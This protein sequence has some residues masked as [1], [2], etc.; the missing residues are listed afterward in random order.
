MHREEYYARI[1][2]EAHRKAL[3][4]DG[5]ADPGAWEQAPAHRADALYHA[6]L[7]TEGL[8]LD[9]V[10]GHEGHVDPK[11]HQFVQG[12]AIMRDKHV[13]ALWRLRSKAMAAAT[14]FER[15]A[16][17]LARVAE[18]E[19]AQRAWEAERDAERDAAEQRQVEAA[20]ERERAA[21]QLARDLAEGE[22]LRRERAELDAQRAA[23]AERVR[24]ERKE[25]QR[26]CDSLVA[27]AGDAS[28]Y[29]ADYVEGPGADVDAPAADEK[30]FR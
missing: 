5:E 16:E 30:P 21:A 24:L 15:T 10:A 7:F 11:T 4:K 6:H 28:S 17:H 23:E 20:A 25:K 12:K 13:M 29:A 18:G 9:P 8:E 27:L 14:P 3:A 19:R 22:R 1:A 26:R 2:H